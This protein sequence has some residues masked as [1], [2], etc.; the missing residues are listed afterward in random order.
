[1]RF[2]N[3]NAVE[4]SLREFVVADDDTMFTSSRELQER[5]ASQK[6]FGATCLG[7]RGALVRSMK[8]DW[9]IVDEASQITIPGVIAPLLHA[10]KFV[11]IG[12][13]QQLPP[14]VRSGEARK[15]GL[16][17]S[18]FQR[19]HAAHPEAVAELRIQYRMA[20]DIQ[21][22]C[23]ELV[24]SSRLSGGNRTVLSQTLFNL[25]PSDL[26]D[27]PAAQRAVLS[28]KSVVFIDTATF[29]DKSETMEK[30]ESE[31]IY[32]DFEAVVVG[33]MVRYLVMNA[34][35]IDQVGVITPYKRQIRAIK[36]AIE[37]KLNK[38]PSVVAPV[39][40]AK[41]KEDLEV[42]TVDKYQGKDKNCIFVSLVRCNEAHN[43]GELL[44]DWR[45]LN[46]AFT[47]AKAKLVVVGNSQTLSSSPFLRRFLQLC[48]RRG[49]V[50]S[51]ACDGAMHPQLTQSLSSM[52]QF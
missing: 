21:T 12:D 35:P 7:M 42:S 18:L 47:R 5:L 34:Y 26:A 20:A 13:H 37:D 48:A 9:C 2:G 30:L 23:N 45:R 27:L 31:A 43:V 14:L 8:F 51:M 44:S 33:D 17:E 39:A 3:V 19:L 1:M 4:P 15:Q 28:L 24:Y 29:P 11:L 16:E 22:V 46:V 10:R 50:E 32:N 38:L 52:F 36:A 6:V 41:S 40:V 25:E 49:W